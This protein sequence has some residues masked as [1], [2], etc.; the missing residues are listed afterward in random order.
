MKAYVAVDI[1]KGE[2]PVILGVFGTLHE[3]KDKCKWEYYS[4]TDASEEESTIAW[5]E[6]PSGIMTGIPDEDG[7]T[8]YKVEEFDITNIIQP[9]KDEI[10]QLRDTIRRS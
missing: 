1:M 5:T 9:L 6:R 4:S 7:D 10:L 2:E 8:Y 3:A